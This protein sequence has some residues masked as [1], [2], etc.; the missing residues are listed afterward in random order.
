MIKQPVTGD[1][2]LFNITIKIMIK[3]QQETG[4]MNI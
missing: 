1:F 2:F 3:T 4:E